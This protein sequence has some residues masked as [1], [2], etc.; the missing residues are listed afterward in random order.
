MDILPVSNLPRIIEHSRNDEREQPQRR[1]PQRKKEQ[2]VSGPVYTPDGH[3]EQD[4]V[5]KIDIVA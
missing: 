1:Q 2:I 4:S 3:L 5:S